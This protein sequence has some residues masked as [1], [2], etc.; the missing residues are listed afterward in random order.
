MAVKYKQYY[1]QMIDQNRQAFDDFMKLHDQYVASQI[2]QD[3][4]NQKGMKVLDIV[5]DWDRRL[6]AAQ[7]KG[8]YSQ[9]TTKLS[10]KFWDLVRQDFS[11]IDKVGVKIKPAK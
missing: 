2:S 10:E 7:G 4:Y 6:C 9:Y 3:E 5:R 11:H 8:M 1:Q